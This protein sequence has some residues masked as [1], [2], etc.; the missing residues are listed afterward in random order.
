LRQVWVVD[1]SGH[2]DGADEGTKGEDRFALSGLSVGVVDEVR[3]NGEANLHLAGIGG[4]GRASSAGNIYR[5]AGHA[6]AGL[7]MVPVPGAQV[8]VD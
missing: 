8:A 3:Q 2:G 7:G 4:S 5:H 1:C 6:T